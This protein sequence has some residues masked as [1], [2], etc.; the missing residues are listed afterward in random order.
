MD[1]ISSPQT[2]IDSE[3]F[4]IAPDIYWIGKKSGADLEMNVFLR[5]FRKGNQELNMI[6]DPG[7]P[8]DFKVVEANVKKVLGDNY[9]LHFAFIN[10]QDPDVG[11]N[12]IYFQ[13]YFPNMQ[14]ITTED[15]WRLI[16]LYGFNP[17]KFIAVDKFK[18]KTIKLVTGHKMVFVPT[19]YCHF[20]GACAL[21]DSTERILFSGDFFGG[22]TDKPGFYAD[23]SAW[24]G[25]RIFHQI[26]MPANI[27]LKNAIKNI[28]KIDPQPAIIATQHGKIIKGE[29]VSY[30][31][32][33]M[34]NLQVGLDLSDHGNVYISQYM[35]AFNTILHEAKIQL[36]NA[37][38]QKI[39]N[40][41]F[42]DDSFPEIFEIKNEEIFEV[43]IGIE[44]AMQF[45][46]NLLMADQPAHIKQ[47]LRMITLNALTDLNLPMDGLSMDAVGDDENEVPIS[48]VDDIPEENSFDLK[49]I[50]S[51][52]IRNLLQFIEDET[53]SDKFNE[54]TLLR[55]M[56]KMPPSI[57]KR[58]KVNSYPDLYQLETT[59]DNEFI[60]SLV[61]ATESIL[62]Q[63]LPVQLFESND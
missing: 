63:K 23:E 3:P 17:K 10:H 33:K 46:I 34:N 22:L 47:K 29:F 62:G 13:R 37:D 12:A 57:L 40:R 35:Q 44:D 7:P 19:P 38:Y 30:F 28:T 14:I 26:Y 8:T 41:L 61:H 52:N 56:L 60:E 50:T 55:I 20:R 58:N 15:T 4:E 11:Y 31:M 27:A 6:I 5:R 2:I 16:R 51:L 18:S 48:H 49:S 43:K 53:D 59:S 32:D 25:I 24:S 1:S 54:L 36:D 9:K 21:Y 39:F 45:F 42:T